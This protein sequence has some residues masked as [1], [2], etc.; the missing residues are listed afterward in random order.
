[1]MEQGREPHFL[2]LLRYFPHTF[3]P[4]GPAFPVLRPALV[5]LFRVLLGQR[6]FLHNLRRRSPALVRLLRRYYAAVRLPAA[7]REGLTAH[8]VLPPAR[9]LLPAGG[10]GVSRFSRMEFLCVLG[11]C[12]SAGHGT[13]ALTRTALL[14]SVQADAVGSLICRFRSSIPSPHMPLSNASSA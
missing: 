2:V 11:V 4:A 7:V 13:L 8:R 3:Q 14:P 1:M 6:P 9:R 10:H 5:R 12:D